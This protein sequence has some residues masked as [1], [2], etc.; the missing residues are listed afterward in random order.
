MIRWFK[1]FIE[2]YLKNFNLSIQNVYFVYLGANPNLVSFFNNIEIVEGSKVLETIVQ[3]SVLFE[4]NK[5][6][7]TDR[8]NFFEEK[9]NPIYGKVPSTN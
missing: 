2:N 5:I 1:Y 7:Q 6:S 9:F 3:I 4:K 8:K